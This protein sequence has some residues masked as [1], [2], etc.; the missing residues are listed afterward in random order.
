MT[1]HLIS[2]AL[3]A[4]LM[5]QAAIANNI[6]N[7]HTT[8]YQG[9]RV[10]FEEQ[11]QSLHPHQATPFYEQAGKAPDLENELALGITNT[12]QYRALIKGLNYQLAI[13]R[14]AIQGSRA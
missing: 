1:I 7:I 10:N 11:L 3:D 9:I 2:K 6:S 12:T 8:G 5:R 14:L 4:A 13:T